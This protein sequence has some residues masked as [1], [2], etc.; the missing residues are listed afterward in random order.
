LFIS[1]RTV[2]N[3]VARIFAKL[4]ARTRTAAVTMAIASGL[5]D[6]NEHPPP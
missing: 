1:V 4:G 2:E 3:H 5:V 6:P